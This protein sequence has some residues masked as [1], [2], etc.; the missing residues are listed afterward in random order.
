VL[1]CDE[2]GVDPVT[3]QQMLGHWHV[4]TTM[5]YVSPS[6]TLIED[7]DRRALADTPAELTAGPSYGPL[8]LSSRTAACASAMYARYAPLW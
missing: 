5:R 2:R 4:D 1:S 7:A 6:S 3:I 8:G